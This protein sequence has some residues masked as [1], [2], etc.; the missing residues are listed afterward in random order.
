MSLPFN[1]YLKQV[2]LSKKDP[3][4]NPMSQEKAAKLLY[5]S[6][7]TYRAWEASPPRHLP[8]YRSRRRLEEV[9]PEI[10]NQKG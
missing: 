3:F 8:D 1:E 2:R 4:G 9:W 7:S 5:V 6:I 10:F